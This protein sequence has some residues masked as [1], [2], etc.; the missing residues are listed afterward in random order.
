VPLER[1]VVTAV[2]SRAP[3][4]LGATP[5][6]VSIIE[7]EDLERTHARDIR[8]AL[9]YEPDISVEYAAARFGLG[10]IAIRGLEGNRV[11]YLEDGI[12]LPDTYKIGSFSNASRNPFS[13]ALLSRIEV[14]RGPAS[15]LYGA[16]ALAGVVAMSTLDPRDLVRPGAAAGGFVDAEYVDADRSFI[17]T[18][19]AAARGGFEVLGAVSRA[20]G[21]ERGNRGDVGA[22][23]ATRTRP[24]PQDARAESQLFKAVLPVGAATRWRAAY[25][26]FERQVATDVLSL[27]PQSPKTVSLAADDAAR[28]ERASLDVE[29]LDWRGAERLAWLA[30]RQRSNTDQA[31]TEVRAGTTAQCLSAS[32]NVTCKREARF[33]FEQEETGTSLVASWLRGAHHA[34]AGAEASRTR[35]EEMRDG[36]Q[37]NLNTGATT[38]IVGT[39]VFPTRD[40]PASRLDRAGAFAQ[41]DVA[42]GRAHVI[43]A[44]RYDRFATKAE[45]DAIFA[46][47][48]PGRAAVDSTN[49]AWSP[50]LGALI[51]LGP[52]HALALQYATG[53]R[54]PP[55]FDVNIGI[56]NLPLGYTV[57]PNP[58]LKPETSRG[59]EASLRGHS[60][61]I[62]YSVTAYGTDYDDLIVSRAPLP[63]PGDPRCVPSAP[64]TFQSQNV[65]RARIVGAEVRATAAFVDWRAHLGAAWSRGDDRAKSLPL[66]T[67]DPAKVVAG[68]TWEPRG[69]PWDVEIVG[70]AVS[71][72]TRIDTSAGAINATPGFATVDILGRLRIGSHVT[73]RAGVFNLFDREYWIWSDVRGLVNPGASF[74]RYTQPGRTFGVGFKV[75]L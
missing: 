18:V 50:K 32:G 3:E 37:T 16:D 28:R 31:T 8:D 7:R 62:D 26:R 70:T 12:R 27:N 2:A 5:A 4:P 29:A 55:Y 64:I 51:E 17:R 61:R 65:S 58:D 66:N 44:L 20:D 74:D 63:C 68:L 9:R 21:H 1:I 53:F 72:K 22:L 14:L 57:I 35:I 41:D 24:N 71:R 59:I 49:S 40:F 54:A 47:S 19:A 30:Y 43:P 39:D 23:G 69:A 25:E 10:N 13:T 42:F 48:N 52:A 11:Q 60:G 46:A 33:H 75:E 6:S 56:S 67:I 38:N 36:L 15:A 45:P 34:V 73:V